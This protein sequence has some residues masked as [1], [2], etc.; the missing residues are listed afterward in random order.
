MEYIIH[1]G[2]PEGSVLKSMIKLHEDIFDSAAGML[3]EA[4]TKHGL[5]TIVAIENGEVIGCKI[6]YN[7]KAYHFYSWLGGVSGNFRKHGIGSELMRRQ[8]EWLQQNG[9]KTI[10]THTKN[11]WRSMLILNLKHGFDVIGTFTDSRGEPKIILEKRL[12]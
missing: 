2:V 3:L 1:Q 12:S 10:R 7:R 8:H 9:Y 11:Q 6:G 5:L 4:Q